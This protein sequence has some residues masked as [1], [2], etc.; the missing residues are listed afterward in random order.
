MKH[1]IN[2]VT[3]ISTDGKT[4]SITAS[5]EDLPFQENIITRV[6]HPHN[7][8]IAEHVRHIQSSNA[9]VFVR[10]RGSSVLFP[11]ESLIA[12]AAAIE[13]CTSFPP[14]FC[15]G[16]KLTVHSELPFT[17]QWQFSDNAFPIADKPNTPPPD[18]VWADVEGQTKAAI[19]DS[20]VKS[21]QWI[22]V[23]ATNS[24][25]KT[26]SKPIKVK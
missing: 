14:R 25:G 8:V 4:V 23:V 16:E 13:P 5:I 11:N 21:G 22:R 3:T 6:T 7:D 17:L 9:A 19:D 15:K 18:A 26:I 24:A 1:L 2:P 20:K 12:I 10:H